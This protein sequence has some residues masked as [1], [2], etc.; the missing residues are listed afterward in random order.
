MGGEWSLGVALVMELWPENSR[1]MLAGLIGAAANVGFLFI[2]VVG[3]FISAFLADIGTLFRN[4]GMAETSVQWLTGHQGWRLLLMFGAVP[5]LLTFF[6]RIFVPESARWE[7]EQKKG[8]TSHWATFD[9]IGVLIGAAGAC[10]ILPIFL[11]PRVWDWAEG[12]DWRVQLP[13][14]LVCFAIA[15]IG[16]TYPVLRYLQRSQTATTDPLHAVGPTL[17]RM[18][19]GAC[20][21][22]VAL[23]GTWGA[24]Q[25]LPSWAGQLAE[26]Q[27]MARSYTQIASATGAIFGTI[28]GALIGDWLGRRITYTLL[29]ILSLVCSLVLYQFVDSYGAIFLAGVFLVGGVTAS[30]YGW[31]PLYLPEL[32]RTGVRATGQGFSFN[33]GR[34]LAA[35]GVLQTGYLMSSVFGGDYPQALTVISLVYIIGI[36]LIWFAPETKGKPLPE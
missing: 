33:F 32:F 25:W 35:I 30:F 19:L 9:L 3:L 10:M 1:G 7:E 15:V 16:F 34:I 11:A 24:A 26:G 23:L 27:A 6:I 17:K 21:G 20:L 8:T 36:V 31:L 13:A 29:C 12:L 18:L 14:T 2:A 4:L 5:A 22:G 28:A